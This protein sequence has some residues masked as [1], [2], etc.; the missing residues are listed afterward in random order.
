MRPKPGFGSGSATGR[1]LDR[2]RLRGMI[3]AQPTRTQTR[4][5]AQRDR[6][7]GPALKQVETTAHGAPQ[8]HNARALPITTDAWMGP[9]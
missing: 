2:A 9:K 4:R 3:G 7:T 1:L 8:V 6:S 5:N